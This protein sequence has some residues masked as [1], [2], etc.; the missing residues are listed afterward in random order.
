M[1]L[2]NWI[3]SLTGWRYV[4]AVLLIAFPLAIIETPIMAFVSEILASRDARPE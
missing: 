3:R 4:A 2:N 1:K